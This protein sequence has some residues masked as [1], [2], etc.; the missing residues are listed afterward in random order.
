MTVGKNGGWTA[1]GGAGERGVSCDGPFGAG[2]DG[3]AS[4]D[5]ASGGMASDDV[6]SEEHLAAGSDAGASHTDDDFAG[7]DPAGDDLAGDE[8]PDG[9]R[10]DDV[11]TEYHVVE[12]AYA[13]LELDEYLCLVY[14]GVPKGALREEVRS[15]RVTLDGAR[16]Q[17]SK[18]VRS[19]SVVIARIADDVL[20]KRRRAQV[21]PLA[22]LWEDAHQ[23][24][25]EK[26]AGLAVEP[27]RWDPEGGCVIDALLAWARD[28]RDDGATPLFR[29]RLVHRLDKDTSGALVVAKDLAAERRLA[30]AFAAGSVRKEY[31]ALVE[32]VPNLADGEVST[33]DLPLAEDARRAGRVRVDLRRGKPSRTDIW[34]ERRFDGY[35]LLRCRLHTGRTHQIRVHL[36]HIGLPLAIDPVYGRRDAFLLSSVKRGYRPK[37]GRTERPLMERQTLHAE[38]LVVPTA[39]VDAAALA[40]QPPS[41]PPDHPVGEVFAQGPWV[42]VRAPLPADLARVIKQLSKV[43]PPRR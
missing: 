34:I 9:R 3:G 29:P 26:P 4:D 20:A 39:D 42:G 1:H 37:R 33:I 16:V 10:G 30:A 5:T 43:R 35:S 12:D 25:V 31:L 32:G 7:D 13:G 6:V 28:G 18:R 38:T 24:V 22:V 27:E 11:A 17:P 36:A 14:P 15:G 2:A 21:P 19:G 40:A 41:I 23:A 8:A